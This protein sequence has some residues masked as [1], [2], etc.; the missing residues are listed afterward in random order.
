MKKRIIIP[1]ILSA[2]LATGLTSCVKDNESDSVKNLREAKAEELRGSAEYHKAMAEH[3][4]AKATHKLAEAKKE[5]WLA[6]VQEYN[7]AVKQVEVLTAQREEALAAAGQA[8]KVKKAE[9]E[10]EAARIQAQS[11]VASATAAYE[12][13][14]VDVAKKAA[15]AA[16]AAEVAKTALIEKKANEYNKVANEY[17]GVLVDVATTTAKITETEKEILG[18]KQGVL[19]AE[20]VKARY[21]D[22]RT[23]TITTKQAF[24]E[25]IK[26]VVG[27]KGTVSL[28]DVEK[29]DA[30]LK[31]LQLEAT[32]FTSTLV[33]ETLTKTVVDAEKTFSSTTE[34]TPGYLIAKFL[35]T[36]TAGN[37]SEANFDLVVKTNELP[38]LS[39]DVGGAPKLYSDYKQ[40]ELVIDI[41]KSSPLYSELH[42]KREDIRTQ[43]DEDKGRLKVLNGPV[44]EVGSVAEAHKAQADAKKQYEDDLKNNGATHAI[45]I[46]S[47]TAYL[48]AVEAY[49]NRQIERDNLSVEVDGVSAKV[50]MYDAIIDILE[51][52]D[53]AAVVKMKADIKAYNEAVAKAAAR[54]FEEERVQEPVKVE[55]A[56]NT[57]LK[58]IQNGYTTF[59]DALKT[60]YEAIETAKK[61]IEEYREE[62]KQTGAV[63]ALLKAEADLQKY[64]AQKVTLEALAKIL[65]AKMANLKP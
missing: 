31:Q 12:Q 34:G 9:M 51:N 15:D 20:A 61:E 46:A 28:S 18:L 29:S 50:E 16:V 48:N 52:P 36:E 1:A 55:Q 35:E 44:S 42:K 25:A 47:R 2:V 30:K 10:A 45:T 26:N 49:R 53:N 19:N 39:E 14:L 60:A 64:K 8:D 65:E 5:E 59:E 33:Y 27:D 32:L 63:Y 58:S 38:Q 41:T 22:Q 57:S 54:W 17:Y 21:I 24:I 6:K 43:A 40:K 56:V 4:K 11:A 3:E 62:Y 23:R 37:I 7:A 13:A